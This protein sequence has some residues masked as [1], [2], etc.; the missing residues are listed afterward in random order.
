[1]PPRAGANARRVGERED[2]VKVERLDGR[3]LLVEFVN[4]A[5][6][7]EGE[8]GMN[9]GRGRLQVSGESN[10]EVNLRSFRLSRN[11]IK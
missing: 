8:Q 11:Y 7:S 1:L 6:R 2:D 4:K 9:L 3:N 10:V 5:K